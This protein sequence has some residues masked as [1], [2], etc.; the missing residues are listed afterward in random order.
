MP[1]LH[2]CYQLAA[3]KSTSRA[4]QNPSICLQ[5]YRN[6]P[7]LPFQRQWGEMTLSN[8]LIFLPPYLTETKGI[9]Y[10]Q[11][12]EPWTKLLRVERDR[13]KRLECKDTK[14]ACPVCDFF[15]VL[16]LRRTSFGPK[17]EIHTGQGISFYLT[18]PLENWVV[19]RKPS[20]KGEWPFE[21]L[22]NSSYPT[23]GQ[24]LSVP[25]GALRVEFIAG[26]VS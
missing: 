12:G 21:S 26:S 1:F 22:E 10:S 25:A 2:K 18:E 11:P 13:N 16:C 19:Q 17:Y 5:F 9:E 8:L 20:P 24:I 4:E 3:Q 23:S 6:S 15:Q 7:L 14:K